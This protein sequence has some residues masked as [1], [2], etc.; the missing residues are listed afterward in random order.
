MVHSGRN[1][2]HFIRKSKPGALLRA[3][4]D[5]LLG[6]QG[7]LQVIAVPY[8]CG[9]KD[10]VHS[11]ALKFKLQFRLS[12]VLYQWMQPVLMR[13]RILTTNKPYNPLNI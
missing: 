13:A 8:R 2:L 10:T 1:E 7:Q 6:T 4:C 3:T 9:Q 5:H 12:K 11:Q